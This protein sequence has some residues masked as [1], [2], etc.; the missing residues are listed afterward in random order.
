MNRFQGFAAGAIVALGL[1]LRPMASVM[2]ISTQPHESSSHAEEP[3]TDSNAEGP[4]KASSMYWAPARVIAEET[5]DSKTTVSISIE[6]NGTEAKSSA[7]TS[8]KPDVSKRLSYKG[9]NDPQWGIPSKLGSPAKIQ[10]VIAVVPD[11]LRTHLALDFDRDID[12]LIQAAGDNDYVPSY[13]WLPWKAH[14]GSL[15]AEESAGNANT[16]ED[17]DLLRQPGLIVLKHVSSKDLQSNFYNVIYLFLVG[18]TPTLGIDGAQFKNAIKYE[19]ELSLKF[20]HSGANFSTSMRSGG[21][22]SLAIIGPSDS[23]SAASLKAAI[24]SSIKNLTQNKKENNNFTIKNVQMAGTTQT[25]LASSILN[26]SG[27]DTGPTTIYASFAENEAYETNQFL[28]AIYSFRRL[29]SFR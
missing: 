6:V 29:H 26:N 17:S 22:G 13:F 2:P 18:E 20:Q 10:A 24:K 21:E 28:S 4:W 9:A 7:Q 1:L 12:A 14:A 23:G 27:N 16:D 15:R 11:P 25:E 8:A 19:S 3:K 5:N